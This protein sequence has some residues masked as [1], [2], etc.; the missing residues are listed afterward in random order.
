MVRHARPPLLSVN[1]TKSGP[2]HPHY[3]CFEGS[4]HR[5]VDNCCCLLDGEILCCFVTEMQQ[6]KVYDP[7]PNHALL[8]CT[9]NDCKAP[10]SLILLSSF[11]L[12]ALASLFSLTAATPQPTV[13]CVSH[14]AVLAE[15]SSSSFSYRT[16]SSPAVYKEK[17]RRLSSISFSSP[18]HSSGAWVGGSGQHSTQLL[19]AQRRRQHRRLPA[20]LIHSV[21]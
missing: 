6:S 4:R 7:P 12:S 16:V 17:G 9:F 11:S 5:I 2:P 1:S 20:A 14:A 19:G 15:L 3:E 18:L 21:H 10:S 8:H 13:R